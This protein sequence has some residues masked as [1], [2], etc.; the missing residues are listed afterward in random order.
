MTYPHY[1]HSRN[2]TSIWMLISTVWIMSI[3]VSLAPLLG[4]KDANWEEKVEAGWR[5]IKRYQDTLQQSQEQLEAAQQMIEECHEKYLAAD[6]TVRTCVCMYR[7]VAEQL[8][9]RDRIYRSF[10][11]GL[12]RLDSV[13]SLPLLN[14][15]LKREPV[16]VRVDHLII[17]N[18]CGAVH[19]Y[20]AR[21]G[22]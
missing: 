22:S 2:S 20:P 6:Q 13:E 12:S 21:G 5:E 8:R 15:I 3:I 7:L 11:L 17:G 19:T 16:S 9:E 1:I 14:R 4:W 10:I 18:N